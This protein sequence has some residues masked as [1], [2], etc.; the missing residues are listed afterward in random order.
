MNTI[1]TFI[2]QKIIPNLAVIGV[3]SFTAVTSSVAAYRISQD[4]PPVQQLKN[5]L[6]IRV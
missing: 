6:L 3:V 4:L 1:I 5:T 2:V